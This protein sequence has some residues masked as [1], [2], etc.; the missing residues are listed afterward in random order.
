MTFSLSPSP[1]RPAKRAR[2]S[3]E[4]QSWSWSRFVREP[5]MK[6][7]CSSFLLGSRS[8]KFS[9]LRPTLR[10][11]V[12]PEKL[13]A[14]L[15]VEMLASGSSAYHCSRWSRAPKNAQTQMHQ[16]RPNGSSVLLQNST[17]GRK[18]HLV[19]SLQ[20]PAPPLHQLRPAKPARVA[21]VWAGA[22][23]EAL[24]YCSRGERKKG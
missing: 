14:A 9:N 3:P 1:P 7:L 8:K 11:G 19:L 21:S 5:V 18:Q 23:K 16:I 4:N 2:S 15:F 12:R 10:Q 22:R 13:E 17:T 24:S 20:I 6:Q